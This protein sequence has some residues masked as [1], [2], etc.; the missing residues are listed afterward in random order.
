VT[1][2]YGHR[3]TP[4]GNSEFN[5][6]YLPERDGGC[7]YRGHDSP[8]P[9]IDTFGGP[10]ELDVDF[11]GLVIDAANGNEVIATKDWRVKCRRP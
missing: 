1:F 7:Q 2:F 4:N 10:V 5:D 8:N 9:G 3:G 11:R 6:R